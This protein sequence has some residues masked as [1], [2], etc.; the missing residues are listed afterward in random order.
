MII[1]FAAT[2]IRALSNRHIRHRRW[3][4]DHTMH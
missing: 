3:R 1:A 4:A 2:A